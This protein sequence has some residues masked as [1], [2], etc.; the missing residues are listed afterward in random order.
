MRTL[1]GASAAFHPPTGRTGGEKVPPGKVS[2]VSPPAGVS[3]KEQATTLDGTEK[4]RFVIAPGVTLPVT[5]TLASLDNP[6]LT[7]TTTISKP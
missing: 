6:A 5:L 4:V 1:R 7:C 3:I 2:L